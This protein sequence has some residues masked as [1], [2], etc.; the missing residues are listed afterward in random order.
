VLPIYSITARGQDGSGSHTFAGMR[1]EC[2]A[3]AQLFFPDS[4]TV[5][6]V[7][8]LTFEQVGPDGPWDARELIRRIMAGSAVDDAVRL[9]PHGAGSTK[10]VARGRKTLDLKECDRV[11]R[12]A[13]D[14]LADVIF[15]LIYK[16]D[17]HIA[18]AETAGPEA[19][20]AAEERFI[21]ESADRIAKELGVADK[22]PQ[23]SQEQSDDQE[24]DLN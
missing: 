1:N 20:A 21:Q 15:G 3:A 2:L 9:R 12:R 18:V 24:D 5:F 23:Q 6:E 14:E 17:D 16:S 22:S 13:I 10:G 8:R 19:E 7:K 11:Y 4:W